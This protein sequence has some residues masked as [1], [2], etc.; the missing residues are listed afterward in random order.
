MV[1]AEEVKEWLPYFFSFFFFFF[2]PRYL[3]A[4]KAAALAGRAEP[5]VGQPG[6]WRWPGMPIARMAINCLNAWPNPW[7]PGDIREYNW[8]YATGGVDNAAG[9]A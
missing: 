2:R 4:L 9:A 6:A 3:Q 5:G 8:R 7:K 1:I